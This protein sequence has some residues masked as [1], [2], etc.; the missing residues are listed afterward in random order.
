MSEGGRTPLKTT[1]HSR[2]RGGRTPSFHG[3][4]SHRLGDP[5]HPVRFLRNFFLVPLC[6]RSF[7]EFWRLW[8]PI[9]GYFLIFFIFRPLRRRMPRPIAVYLTFLASGF[10]LHDLPFNLSAD[11]YRGRLE[12]PAVTLLFAVFGALALLSEA[13][14]LDL[15]RFP[16]WVRAASNL[17]WL[18]TGYGLRHVLLM[19]IRG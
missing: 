16:P 1:D 6:S 14:G 4:I 9:F 11:L 17:G 2:R 8:N 3:F 10:L 12:F 7:G 18:T 19:L 15:S 5:R 13:L